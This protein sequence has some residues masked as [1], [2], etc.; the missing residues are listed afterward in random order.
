MSRTPSSPERT[1]KDFVSAR[2]NGNEAEAAKLTL[3]GNLDDFLGAEYALSGTETTFDVSI[4]QAGS[5]SAVAVVHY[6]WD[7]DSM[8]IPYA[9]TRVSGEWKIDLEGTEQLWLEG[10]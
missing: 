4:S 7:G 9:C 5:E 8:D 10:D 1:L 2:L 6:T 3:Q